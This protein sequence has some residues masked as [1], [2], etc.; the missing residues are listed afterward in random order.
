MFWYRKQFLVYVCVV[1]K[2]PIQNSCETET[3]LMTYHELFSLHLNYGVDMWGNSSKKEL[4][5]HSLYKKTI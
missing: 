5:E 3:L 4:K 2:N 1:P